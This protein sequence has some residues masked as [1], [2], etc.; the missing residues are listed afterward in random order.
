MWKVGATVRALRPENWAAPKSGVRQ[1][2]ARGAKPSL[3]EKPAQKKNTAKQA[4]PGPKRKTANRPASRASQ[5]KSASS[6]LSTAAKAGG[7]QKQGRKR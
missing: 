5:Q 6:R 1:K 7:K 4:K 3:Q 2:S